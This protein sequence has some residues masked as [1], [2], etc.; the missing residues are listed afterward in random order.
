MIN[1]INA[2]LIILLSVFLTCCVTGKNNSVS[3]SHK[4]IF[5]DDFEGPKLDLSKW[6]VEITGNT[7]NNELQAYVDSSLTIFTTFGSEAKGASNGVLVLQPHFIQGY[8]SKEGK[9]YD[10][11][12]GRINT[13]NKFQFTY[14]TAEARIKLTEGS[15]LWPAWWML[16]NGRWPDIG[17]ID[18]MEYVGEQ[19]W[20]SAAV[21]GPGYSGETPFVNRMFFTRKNDVTQWHIYGV[22]WTPDALIFKY[23]QE[24]MFRVNKP[25]VEHYGKWAFDNPKYLILNFALGGAYPKKVN[26]VNSP[27]YGLPN[28]TVE[29]IKQH[30]AKMIVDWIKI[31]E[32]Y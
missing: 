24:I 32:N 25:M 16:G 31:S 3:K 5:F 17:E 14:G 8:T 29:K 2:G 19:D 26:G 13:R 1:K 28:S 20:A 7:V 23:D 9:K 11:I 15:G 12:S 27:Y 21:H 10:F 6:N 4:I 18:I 30:D 22:D